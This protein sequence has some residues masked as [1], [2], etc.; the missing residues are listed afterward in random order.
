ME[1]HQNNQQNIL[2]VGHASSVNSQS[3][4]VYYEPY[5]GDVY[6]DYLENR[7]MGS[8]TGDSYQGGLE[9]GSA[10]LGTSMASLGLNRTNQFGSM[11]GRLATL[12]RVQTVEKFKDLSLPAV[13]E[14]LAN[15][16]EGI[17]TNAAAYIQHLT[18]NNPENKHLVREA[19]AI[20]VLISV[21][22]ERGA[23]NKLLEHA[24]G[25]LRNS[26][27]GCNENK[28][29]I[30]KY[31]GISALLKLLRQRRDVPM[32]KVHVTG[33]LWNLSSHHSLKQP[34][35]DQV[36]NDVVQIVLAPY[37]AELRQNGLHS[38]YSRQNGLVQS[39][40]NCSGL[41]RNLSSH[42]EAARRRLRDVDGLIDSLCDIIEIVAS[43][44]DDEVANC[45]GVEG[46]VCA[47]RNLTFRIHREASSKE[48]CP[49]LT[50]EKQG[51]FWRPRLVQAP[52]KEPRVPP[53][54]ITAK[55][56]ERL[57]QISILPPLVF[58]ISESSNPQ[59]IEASIGIVQNLT[60]D[61]FYS[62][63]YLRAH[64]RKEKGLPLLV[65]KIADQS[66]TISNTAIISLRN[67]AVDLKNKELIGKYGMGEVCANIPDAKQAAVDDKIA[68]A[69]LF[70]AK[71]LVEYHSENA[72]KFVEHKGVLK[73]T[74]I[75]ESKHYS[76]KIRKVA[77]QVLSALWQIKQ[78]R[79]SY[80]NDLGLKKSNFQPQV[81]HD[82][83]T[84][85]PARAKNG[86]SWV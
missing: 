42:S 38:S 56:V 64:F 2:R 68:L 69:A 72:Q 16:D 29:S 35:L 8:F 78:L 61:N 62:S 3:V 83:E 53:P 32:I 24:A 5:E 50:V 79:K 60:S 75:N 58:F 85:R 19:G 47:L 23:S 46:T 25:A 17:S 57:I 7:S 28:Q 63:A 77:G 54:N 26:S 49:Q 81:L 51:C 82:G 13:V 52:Y 80:K 18:Y 84:I 14:L 59:T 4:G 15:G 41:I 27:Y 71:T 37:A 10:D 1:A 36:I 11:S 34:L 6:E 74:A 30:K 55:G 40:V 45:K 43:I 33:T 12:G 48:F 70:L 9:V 31:E 73:I 65:E 20:E 44:A 86:D 22:E 76:N 67:L 21:L 39:F 66:R